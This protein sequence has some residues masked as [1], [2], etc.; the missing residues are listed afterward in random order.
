MT[1][2]SAHRAEVL[3]LLRRCKVQYTDVQE[4]SDGKVLVHLPMQKSDPLNTIRKL[5]AGM[6]EE[7]G[8][9]VRYAFDVQRN[10]ETFLFT[11]RK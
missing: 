10:C 5:Y 7:H 11:P 6:D 2:Q 9:G 3:S 4:Q 8:Y 1:D